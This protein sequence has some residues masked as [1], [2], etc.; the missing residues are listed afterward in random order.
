MSEVCSQD[1][2]RCFYFP[3]SIFD[4]PFIIAQTALAGMKNE[5]WEMENPHQ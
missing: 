2:L 1:I 5:N 3:V 4:L